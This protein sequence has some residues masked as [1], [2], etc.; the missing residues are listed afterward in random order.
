MIP[1]HRNWRDHVVGKAGAMPPPATVPDRAV[2]KL[3]D[4]AGREIE[5]RRPI[6]FVDKRRR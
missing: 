1:K 6:G 3:F 5:M 4:A 2:V